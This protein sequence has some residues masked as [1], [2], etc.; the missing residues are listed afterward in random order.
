[1]RRLLKWLGIIVGV[2]L[3]VIVAAAVILYVVGRNNLNKT[4]DVSVEA[5]AIPAG[6]EEALARGQHI[7][8]AISLCAECHGSNLGG[9]EFIDDALFGS[10]DAPNLT[11]G[12]GGIGATYTDEDW[13][14]VLRHGVKPNGKSVKLMPSQHYAHMTDADLAAVIAYAQ[15]VPP[16]DNETEELSLGIVGTI[17]IGNM[18]DSPAKQIESDDIQPAMVEPGVTVEYGEYL[19]TIA[20]CKDCHGEDLDGDLGVPG[21]P[22]GPDLTT[23]DGWTEQDFINTIRQGINPDGDQLDPDEMPWNYYTRMTDDELSAMWAYIQTQ[24]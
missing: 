13:V 20:A 16:V 4:Y 6:D 2:L 9:D 24:Q 17:M 8:E 15:S 10:G 7:A 1:M 23:L 22:A 12:T 11:A 5:L 21:P 14:R 3:L 19:I 18:M